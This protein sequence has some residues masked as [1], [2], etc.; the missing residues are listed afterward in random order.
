L[1]KTELSGEFSAD[2]VSSPSRLCTIPHS[3]RDFRGAITHPVSM[4]AS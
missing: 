2:K 3:L 4:D 1:G